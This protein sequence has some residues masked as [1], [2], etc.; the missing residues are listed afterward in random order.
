VL[1]LVHS[2]SVRPSGER[3]HRRAAK[4]EVKPAS[5]TAFQSA[6]RQFFRFSPIPCSPF[7]KHT[8]NPLLA[9]AVLWIGP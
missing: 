7:P 8:P 2:I 3:S 1:A 6:P 4:G 5:P 9:I